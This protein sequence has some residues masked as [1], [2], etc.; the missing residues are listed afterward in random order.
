MVADEANYRR[1]REKNPTQGLLFFDMMTMTRAG[2]ISENRDHFCL[3]IVADTSEE[4]HMVAIAY[5]FYKVR[6]N[7]DLGSRLPQISGSAFKELEAS[8]SEEQQE[9]LFSAIGS[10][11]GLENEKLGAVLTSIQRLDR[12]CED[13]VSRFDVEL[14]KETRAKR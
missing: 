6:T 10:V 2:D 9:L 4:S 8:L 1:Y 14:L 13:I 3:N 12:A 11:V 5:R 7:R